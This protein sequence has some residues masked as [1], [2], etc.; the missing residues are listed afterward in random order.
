MGRLIMHVDMDAFFASVEQ[1]DHPEYRGKPVIVGGL[2]ARGV[3]S[4]ASYEARRFGVHSAQAMSIARRRCPQGIFVP[5]RHGRYKE[6]SQQ[7]FTIFHNYSP[8][9]EPLSID[10]GFLDISGMEH[11]MDSPEEYG[12]RLKAE[13]FAQ[14]GLVASVGIAPNKFLAKLA[15][16]LDKPDGLTVIRNADIPSVVW[17]LSLDHIF[18]VG[19]KTSERL[20][21]AGFYT[22]GDI[23]LAEQALAGVPQAGERSRAAANRLLRAV[24]ER[25]AHEL[26][27]LAC[28]RDNRPVSPEREAKSIGRETT[29]ETDISLDTEALPELLKLSEEVGWRLRREGHQ[30]RTVQLKLRYADFTT[31]TRRKTLPQPVSFDEDIYRTACELLATVPRLHGDKVRLLGV[32]AA[33]LDEPE[34][35]RELDLFAAA[36]DE[37]NGKKQ[38]LYTALD[39]LK[40]KYGEKI[41]TKAGSKKK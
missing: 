22:I 11:L 12:R 2:S 24:G 23:A 33:S 15:S 20:Q 39:A 8:L 13:I 16:D 28:G 14:T 21:Q 38:Q 29:F 37:D 5:G 32:T 3:V 41:I 17:P 4:T 34:E 6:I 19:K 18:G 31:I 10:E 36:E 25:L 40:Q 27:E 26:T 30:A 1:L 9:V 7:I 35:P